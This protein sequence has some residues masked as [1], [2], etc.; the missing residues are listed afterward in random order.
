VNKQN[1]R[2]ISIIVHPFVY[3]YYREGVITRQMKWF[4]QYKTWIKLIKDSSIGITE[5]HFLNKDGDEIE[6]S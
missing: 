4:G 1:E 5:F 6:L 3:S 2:G